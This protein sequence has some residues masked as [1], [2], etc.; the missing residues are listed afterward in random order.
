MLSEIRQKTSSQENDLLL[1]CQMAMCT[2]QGD[3]LPGKGGGGWEFL[4]T[5]S[6]AVSDVVASSSI[7]TSSFSFFFFSLHVG[8]ATL[9]AK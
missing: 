1:K 8:P 2:L 4:I 3:N 6:S 9:S 5:F 7:L